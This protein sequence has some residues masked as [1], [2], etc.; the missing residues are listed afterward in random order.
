MLFYDHYNNMVLHKVYN[1]ITIYSKNTADKARDRSRWHQLNR[2]VG[3]WAT[4]E[5]NFK[6]KRWFDDRNT[7]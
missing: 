3:G 2:P 4:L 7:V 5:Y 1:I 6:K